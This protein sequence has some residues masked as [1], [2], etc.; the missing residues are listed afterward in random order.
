MV[1]L[2]DRDA[3]AVSTLL[4]LVVRYHEAVSGSDITTGG[5]S[6]QSSLTE[7]G[8]WG[9]RPG[10]GE[11]KPELA[12]LGMGTRLMIEVGTIVGNHRAVADYLSSVCKE[13]DTQLKKWG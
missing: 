8:S 7:I 1:T 2:Y 10:N 11:G 12:T 13:I 9:I 5:N 3:R 6:S 4:A